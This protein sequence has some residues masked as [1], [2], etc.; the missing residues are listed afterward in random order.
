MG[1]KIETFDNMATFQT[2]PCKFGSDTTI[3]VEHDTKAKSA[4]SLKLLREKFD[5]NTRLVLLGDSSKTDDIS[6]LI[7]KGY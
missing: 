7:N 6:T 2:R 5:P 1:C 4:S 3:I